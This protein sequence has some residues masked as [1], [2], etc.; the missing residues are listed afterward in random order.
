MTDATLSAQLKPLPAGQLPD[1][2]PTSAVAHAYCRALARRHYENFT[3][4][5][6]LLPERL[7][8]HVYALYAY[9]RVADDLADEVPDRQQ[10]LALLDWWEQQLEDCYRGRC[11]HPVLVALEDTV[12]R[13]EIPEQPFRDLLR[14]FRQ[15]Q[16]KC[17]Y[18]THEEVLDYCRHS[19]N[20]VGRLVL[21][22]GQMHDAERCRWSDSIC[23][24][25]QL[26]NF[27]QDVKRDYHQGRIY[28]P[29]D[30]CRRHGYDEG[31]FREGVCNESFRQLM[32][33]EVERAERYLRQGVPL[34]ERAEPSLRV[35][36]DLFIRG[37]LAILNRIR[38]QD[39]DV[40]SQRP[41]LGKAT[42]LGLLLASIRRQP[43]MA[44]G[45]R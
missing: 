6:W 11:R 41:K 33:E 37:G 17:R 15:D 44:E 26:A 18:A 29:Q 7:R 42:Q 27:C 13:F 43:L 14:A 34:V 19:A 40:W 8:P 36:I 30:S 12:S 35:D 16:W 20:P 5:S 39:Y 31:M 1:R 23:T 21:Y 28:L 32:R 25:L 2:R 45:K 4:A 22:L 38:R 3:V 9:C 10:S 24:G